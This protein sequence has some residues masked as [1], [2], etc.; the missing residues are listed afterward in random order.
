MKLE[1]AEKYLSKRGCS[2]VECIDDDNNPFYAITILEEIECSETY[3]M[4]AIDNL[5]K[6]RLD[7]AVIELKTEF[8]ERKA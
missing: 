3:G 5:S 6:K 4:V 8:E 1:E 7:D 2:I